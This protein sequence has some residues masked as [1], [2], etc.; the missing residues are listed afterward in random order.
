VSRIPWEASD[1]ASVSR[2]TGCLSASARQICTAASRAVSASS[3]RPRAASGGLVVQRHGQVG[4]EGVRAGRG[5]RA[6]V[7]ARRRRPAEPD[8]ETAAAELGGWVALRRHYQLTDR[9]PDTWTT[10]PALVA[11]LGAL[12]HAWQAASSG[13]E[14]SF[15]RGMYWHDALARVLDRLSNDWMPRVR[16][17]HGVST[18]ASWGD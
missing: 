15:E 5:Q 18:H 17:R 3:R 13:L 11:E 7:A 16:K 10:E 4:Q 12:Q 6:V 14:P 1:R 8:P 2:K 9:I